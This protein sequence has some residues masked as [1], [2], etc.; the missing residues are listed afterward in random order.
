MLLPINANSFK[1]SFLDGN[2][3]LNIVSDNDAWKTLF[4]SN[5]KFTEDTDSLAEIGLGAGT[6][7]PLRFGAKDKLELEIGLQAQLAGGI[8]LVFSPDA[9]ALIGKYGLESE[10]TG[11]KLYVHTFLDSK[12]SGKLGA[13]FPVGPISG[14][15][16]I[17]AGGSVLYRRLKP[18][19]RSASSRT[20]IEDVFGSLRLPHQID[21][22]AKIPGPGEVIALEYGGYL[23]MSAGLTWGYS[24]HGTR[25]FEVRDLKADA[26][27][28]LKVAAGID[29]EFKVAGSFGIEVRQGSEPGWA[30]FVVR[31]KKT[32]SWSFSEDLSFKS[33]LDVK[34]IPDTPR[35]F[36]RALFGA[37]TDG[38]FRAFDLAQKYSSLEEIEKKVGKLSIDYLSKFADKYV[39]AVLSNST[40]QAVLAEVRRVTDLYS[41]IDRKVIAIYEENLGKITGL[42]TTLDTILGFQ[43]LSGFKGIVDP[44]VLD[45]V[46]KLS[47]EKYYDVLLDETEFGNFLGQVRKVKD[48]LDDGVSKIIRDVI[49]DLKREYDLDK[50]FTELAKYDTP[51]KLEALADK[52]LKAFVEQFVGKA[53]EE[54]EDF[55]KVLKEVKKAL[56][57]AESFADKWFG[58][59][60]EAT[61]QSLEFSLRNAYTSSTE[62]DKL[63]D[64]ELK[65]TLKKGRELA[66]AASRGDFAEIIRSY[67]AEFV[68]VNPD[69]VFNRKISKSA[70]LQVN[71]L[72]W[73]FERKSELV[74]KIEH[75]IQTDSSGLVHVFT[76]DTHIEQLTKTSKKKKLLGQMRSNFVLRAVGETAQPADSPDS[77]IDPETNRF[78]IA[79]LNKMAVNYE[80]F[81]EDSDTKPKE[82]LIYLQLAKVMGMIPDTG[83]YLR[84]LER[85]FP[86]GFGHVSVEYAVRYDD[87][88]TRSAFSLSGDGLRNS[89]QEII[90]ETIAARFIGLKEI[91]SNARIGFALRDPQ[92]AFDYWNLGPA[93]LNKHIVAVLPAWFTGGSSDKVVSLMKHQR[94]VLATIYR[95]E[96]RYLDRLVK[97]DALVDD[98]QTAGRGVD[99]DELADAARD[100]VS[101]ADDVDTFGQDNSFFIAF[102][103]LAREGS[104]GK[105]RRESAL[106]LRLKPE[107]GE[108]VVKFITG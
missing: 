45:I 83:E 61:N 74:Q 9:N 8:E 50:I 68:K 90:R 32:R 10:F 73:G 14:T 2:G 95:T 85:Q 92:L 4:D 28:D 62:D 24:M 84:E 34:G 46:R 3:S 107:G 53:F 42:R 77:A 102:D 59:M 6:T 13:G 98:A 11:D 91:E 52:K 93:F 105:W 67:S 39:G 88:T 36:L 37:D 1:A 89:A 47:G 12:L 63:I 56:M 26:N 27:Y 29:V 17:D 86:D 33:K 80:F 35:E 106:I 23:N 21:D 48:F 60:V 82:L 40:L 25:S 49:G 31:K 55:D 30:R 20:I 69:T 41:K 108:E 58:R 81:V 78:V 5:G 51:K 100:F 103:K 15:F 38:F 79:T 44:A 71:I 18:Y 66:E 16:G 97:L 64:V 76:L 54:I 7:K 101:I 65:L 75:A 70:H 87:K 99:L 104:A 57:A 19:D 94:S 96:K 72:G 43:D 22:P